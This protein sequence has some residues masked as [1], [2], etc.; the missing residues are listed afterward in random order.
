MGHMLYVLGNVRISQNQLEEAYSLHERALNN[1]L[2]TSGEEHH[3]TGDAWHK[4]GWHEARLRNFDVAKYGHSSSV[5]VFPITDLSRADLLNALKVYESGFDRKFR[6][7]EVAR[8]SFKLAEVLEE[9]GE[10]EEAAKYRTQADGLRK[11]LTGIAYTPNPGE[12]DYDE[13]VSL[14]AR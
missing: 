9:L 6:D 11:T 10:H 13:L 1:W 2:K 14:W 8:S 4:K 5:F 12:N 7:G 3:K